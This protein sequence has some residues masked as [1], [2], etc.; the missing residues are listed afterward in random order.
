VELA[1][2]S[3]VASMV[4]ENAVYGLS[5]AEIR[6]FPKRIQAVTLPQVQQAIQEL[7]HPDKLVITTAGSGA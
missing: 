3:N 2:P 7:I 6:E 1:N 4:L 5:Q